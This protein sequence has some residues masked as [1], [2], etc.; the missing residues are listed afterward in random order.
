MIFYN[1]QHH[2]I[3]F[4]FPIALFFVFAASAL[5][6]LIL[7]ANVYSESTSD[8]QS[9]DARITPLSY[10]TEKFRSKDAGGSITITQCDG[11][12]VL[13]MSETVSGTT[14]V[15]YI[16]EHE[17]M[18]KEQFVTEDKTLSL[19]DGSEIIASYGF[20]MA[21]PE[22]GLFRFTATDEKGHQASVLLAERSAP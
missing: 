2:V 17:G 4:I 1:R 18:L 20:A 19:A 9:N 14:Y 16:Y 11:T 8:M 21:E 12:D 15:T 3:D 10:V 6:V 22:E 7:A 13:S 5:C